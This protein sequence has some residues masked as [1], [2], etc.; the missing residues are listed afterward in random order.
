[1]NAMC[2]W[3]GR[4][5][6][7]VDGVGVQVHT[8]HVGRRVV[9]VKVAR[10]HA[11]DE[12]KRGIEDVSQRERAEGDVGTLPLE[13]EDHLRRRKDISVGGRQ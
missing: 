10:V 13:G 1:M 11:H 2:R 4:S 5:A 9:K 12:R 6:I 3:E 7:Q 8:D